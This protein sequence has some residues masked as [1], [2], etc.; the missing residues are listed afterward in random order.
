MTAVLRLAIFLDALGLEKHFEWNV[1]GYLIDFRALVMLYEELVETET[2][3]LK[4]SASSCS[5]LDVETLKMTLPCLSAIVGF[6]SMV[7]VT[8]DTGRS[9][10]RPA[11]VYIGLCIIHSCQRIG[12]V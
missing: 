7:L 2:L 8:A 10:S 1:D 6:K 12:K 3:A 4:I 11:Y 5:V 9:C